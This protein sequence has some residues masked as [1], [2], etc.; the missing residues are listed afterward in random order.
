MDY[1]LKNVT[2]VILG[3]KDTNSILELIKATYHLGNRH[4]DLEIH[5][6]KLFLLE[7]SVLEKMLK[8]RGL[9]VQKIQ[10]PFFPEI[11]AYSQIHK[12]I[13]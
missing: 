11:G 8:S 10:K 13:Q 4:V 3:K 9:L 6:Q 12:H 5:S 7:D 2:S 1:D